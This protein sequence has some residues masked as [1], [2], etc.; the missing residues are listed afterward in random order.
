MQ[1]HRHRHI[2]SHGIDHRYLRRLSLPS[3]W[4]ENFRLNFWSLGLISLLQWSATRYLLLPFRIGVR[5]G[6]RVRALTLTL[7]GCRIDSAKVRVR[8]RIKVGVMCL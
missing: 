2:A 8:V 3:R 6:V 4:I 5:V 7:I 1:Q